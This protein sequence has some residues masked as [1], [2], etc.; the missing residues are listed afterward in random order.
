MNTRRWSLVWFAALVCSTDIFA[1]PITAADYD[2]LNLGPAIVGPVGPEVETSLTNEN[3]NSVG[4]L[5]SSVNCPA[6]F[7]QCVPAE[8]PANTIYTYIHVITPGEDAPNDPPFHNPLPVEAFDDVQKFNL[9]FSASG[10]NG[11][12]GFSFSDAADAGVMFEINVNEQ[13]QIIWETMTADWDTGES[14]RFFWQTTQAPSGPDGSYAISNEVGEGVGE[15]PLPSVPI[16]VTEP[17]AAIMF[18]LIGIA[19]Y[20]RDSD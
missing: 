6:S 16:N 10:F 13:D 14:I 2:G 17:F 15:G 8:N 11:V 5:S 4:D 9:G 20:R 1:T 19:L 7:N 12:A 18:I 3:G